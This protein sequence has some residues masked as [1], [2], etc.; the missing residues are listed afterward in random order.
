MADKPNLN[1]LLDDI[2][3]FDFNDVDWNNMGSWPIVGKVI[4]CLILSGGILALGYFLDTKA[5]I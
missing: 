1:A 2:R 5:P 3:N 4:L